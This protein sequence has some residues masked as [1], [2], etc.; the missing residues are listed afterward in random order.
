MPDTLTIESAPQPIHKRV[1]AVQDI[2]DSGLIG[3]SLPQWGSDF[4]K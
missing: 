2:P 3:I 4:L 1:R